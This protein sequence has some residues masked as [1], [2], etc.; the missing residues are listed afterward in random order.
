MSSLRQKK[1]EIEK[2]RL[3]NNDP[4]SC[5]WWGLFLL[6]KRPYQASRTGNEPHAQMRLF[7]APSPGLAIAGAARSRIYA[8]AFTELPRTLY[9]ILAI[10]LGDFEGLLG[11]G[12]LAKG[13]GP[14]K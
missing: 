7:P 10:E 2:H 9:A 14:L 11:I 1:H 4:V 6:I 8:H 13:I 3:N 5:D 12:R